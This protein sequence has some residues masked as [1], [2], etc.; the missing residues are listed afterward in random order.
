[1]VQ[2]HSPRPLFLESMIYITRERHENAK[3]VW[4][5]TRRSCLNAVGHER[6]LFFEFTALQREVAA[7]PHP[8]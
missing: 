2:I 5:K 7:Q 6:S 8:R 3:S 4:S 1:V